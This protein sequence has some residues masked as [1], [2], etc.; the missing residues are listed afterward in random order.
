MDTEKLV[1]RQPQPRRQHRIY[2]EVKF[3]RSLIGIYGRTALNEDDRMFVSFPNTVVY[4]PVPY[5]PQAVGIVMVRAANGSPLAAIYAARSMNLICFIALGYFSI[6]FTPLHKWVMCSLLLLPTTMFQAAS[7][8]ADAF[9]IGICF[10]TVGYVLSLALDE[11]AIRGPQIA[12]I[13]AV[14]V[15]A[16]L[17]KQAYVLLPLIALII[18]CR[19]FPGRAACYLIKTG[20]IVAGFFVAGSWSRLIAHLI[21][22]YRGDVFIDPGQQF[23]GILNDPLRFVGLALSHY[24]THAGGLVVSFFGQ[25]T[26]ND[27]P[28]PLWLPIGLA[29]VMTAL[30]FADRQAGTN[31]P[32]SAKLLAM[33]VFGGTAVLVAFSLYLMW[34]PVGQ[35]PSREFKGG[36][37]FPSHRFCF[38]HSTIAGLPLNGCRVIFRRPSPF[39]QWYHSRSRYTAWSIAIMDDLPISMNETSPK[40][41]VAVIGAGPAGLTAAI[42]CSSKRRCRGHRP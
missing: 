1:C 14:C 22:P 15:L 38:S 7:A 21:A 30:A 4:S 13:F 24:F 10:L 28:L 12:A 11:R 3:D 32:F 26:F 8:S 31:V 20:V 37:L 17:S 39:S 2:P 23:A 16:V 18:P 41:R 34:S 36:I 19:K 35:T 9:T 25:L 6:F 29:I 40:K 42:A 33:A 5:L 27:L